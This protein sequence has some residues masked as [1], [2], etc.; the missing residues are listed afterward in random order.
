[1]IEKVQAGTGWWNR[2]RPSGYWHKS[3]MVLFKFV[4]LS[5]VFKE[6]NSA[7]RSCL[8]R[9]E[10]RKF[11]SVHPQQSDPQPELARPC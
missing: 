10:Q 1:M 6:D 7:R 11:D 3:R 2:A 9:A 4:E 8:L 5:P